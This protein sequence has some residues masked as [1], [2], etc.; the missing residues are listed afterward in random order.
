MENDVPTSPIA[1]F[2]LFDR[3]AA[4]L[5]HMMIM[6]GLFGA[7]CPDNCWERASGSRRTTSSALSRFI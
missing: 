7:A 6:L 1:L 4:R 2:A 3:D 5:T